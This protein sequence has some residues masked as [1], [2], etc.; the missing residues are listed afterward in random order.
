MLAKLAEVTFS[1]A[2]LIA[3]LPV[4][5]PSTILPYLKLCA[6]I[7]ARILIISALENTAQEEDNVAR[8]FID[9][10]SSDAD[11]VFNW[12]ICATSV[13][14][15]CLFVSILAF[16]QFQLSADHPVYEN[17]GTLDH[18]VCAYL[19][20]SLSSSRQYGLWLGKLNAPMVG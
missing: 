18:P 5:S 1:P 8:N 11:S 9:S 12:H 20:M 6:V 2:C 7:S 14:Q 15:L 3:K 19:S 16:V 4:V 10:F 13:F 17:G